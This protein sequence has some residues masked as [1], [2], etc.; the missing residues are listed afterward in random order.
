MNLGGYFYTEEDLRSIGFRKIGKNIK[1]HSR[2]SIYGIENITIGDN[3]RIDDFAII[4]G[5]GLVEIGSYVHIPNFCYIGAT[6]GVTLEDFTTLAPGVM[7]FTLSD[8][9]LG[10]KLTNPTV[11][12]EYT[13]GKAGKVTLRRHVI[14]GAG[15]VI[16]PGSTVGEGSSVGAL[17]LVNKDLK[18][19]G[20]YAGIPAKWIKDR[21]KDML[22]LEKRL[23]DG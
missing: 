6:Y 14:I 1:I 17:S 5:T 7:I 10:N 4:I 3:V 9:Y 2:S 23:K 12:R 20:V 13:G 18:P 11:P 22:L 8:D 15:S 19:W 16:L 21:K